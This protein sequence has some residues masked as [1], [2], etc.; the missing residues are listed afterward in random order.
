MRFAFIGLY[1]IWL[2]LLS[3]SPLVTGL[4]FPPG[5]S[6]AQ[7]ESKDDSSI[8]P[9]APQVSVAPVLPIESFNIKG[10]GGGLVQPHF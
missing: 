2:S 10:R 5:P 8:T 4:D 9:A 3:L 1:R 6:R 7:P